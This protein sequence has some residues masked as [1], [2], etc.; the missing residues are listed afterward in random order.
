MIAASKVDQ[1]S[2]VHDEEAI[3]GAWGGLERAG[4][5]QLGGGGCEDNGEKNGKERA[6]K[7]MT[8]ANQENQRAQTTTETQQR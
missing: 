6:G 8:K 7:R 3:G 1:K 4:R 5:W 2:S